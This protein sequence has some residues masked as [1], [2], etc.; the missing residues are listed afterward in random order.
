MGPTKTVV[1]DVV[2]LTRGL[3]SEKDTPFL[4]GLIHGIGKN[5]EG[6]ASSATI[7]P[8]FPALTCTAQLAY[9]TGKGAAGHGIVGNGFYDRQYCEVRNWHQSSGLVECPRLWHR[10]KEEHPGATVFV[11]GWWH[12][13]HDQG[14]DFFVNVRP[15]Y[16]QDGGKKPDIYTH[17]TDLRHELQGKFGTFPLHRFWGP[18]TGIEAS[19]WIAESSI[20]V[21]K[22]H[23]PTLTFVYLPHMDYSLQKFGPADRLHVPADLRQIDALVERLVNYYEGERRARVII[24]SEYG[25]SPVDRPVCLNKELRRAGWLRI[26]TECGGETLD[27]GESPAFA[28]CDHQIAHVYVRQPSN[29]ERVRTFLATV[30][31]VERVMDGAELDAYYAAKGHGGPGAAAAAGAV[32]AAGRG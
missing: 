3:I 28:V 20:H 26:R 8:A 4:H 16:L 29:V 15:Q 18:T 21:D 31:G 22:A 17:P 1:L 14:I 10:L 25:I 11:N 24:L 12:G 5:N 32:A 23:D 9:T 6:A 30:P 19:R 2:A 13:M 27:C 7:E